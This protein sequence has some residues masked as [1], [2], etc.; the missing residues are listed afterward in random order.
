MLVEEADADVV[1]HD[2]PVEA[3]LVAEH[4]GEEVARGVAGLV[5]DVVVG[6]HD[7]PGVRLLHRHLEREQEDVV[8]LAPAQVHRPVVARPLA[9]GVARVVLERREEV[10]L[11]S[12]QAADEAGA[13][14]AHQVGVLAERLLGAAPAH[15]ARDVEDRRQALVAAH[16]AG[17]APDGLRRALDEVRVP[18]RA[19]GEGRREHRRAAGHQAHQA[20]LV[21]HRGDPE[22]GLLAQ[23]LLQPVERADAGARLDAVAAERAGD[24]PEAVAEGLL[25]RRR[26]RAPGEVVLARAVLAVLGE[27]EPQRVHLRGLLLE[28]HAG[29]EVARALLDGPAG[30]LVGKGHGEPP[31][32]RRP[33][34]ARVCPNSGR[35]GRLSWYRRRDGNDFEP[36]KGPDMDPEPLHAARR[37]PFLVCGFLLLCSSSP[38]CPAGPSPRAGPTARSRRPTRCRRRPLT[39][40]TSPPTERPTPPARR[41]PS[42]RRSRRRSSRS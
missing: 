40:T 27:E 8:Q 18:G 17:L 2:Q 13:Q 3:P 12:L 38:R 39:S 15:V 1:G 29:E 10:P 9:P 26:V 30:F 34:L 14:D 42:P 7:G 37:Q 36:S 31:R 19:V 4:L 22:P 35:T 16:A 24:L 20:L 23:E 21:R 28:R 5:V 33:P 6:R 32:V 41:S 25:D 11:L